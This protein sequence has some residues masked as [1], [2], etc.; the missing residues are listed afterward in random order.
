MINGLGVELSIFGCGI[1]ITHISIQMNYLWKALEVTAMETSSV[2]TATIGIVPD[3]RIRHRRLEAAMRH[4][5]LHGYTLLVPPR[6]IFRKGPPFLF[7]PGEHFL[8]P[9]GSL[10]ARV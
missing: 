5:R 9:R 3:L 6:E 2:R 1:I 10:S 7:P 8:F 4:R